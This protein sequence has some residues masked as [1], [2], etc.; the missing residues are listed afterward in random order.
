MKI[1]IT[2]L[3]WDEIIRDSDTEDL[4]YIRGKI[5]QRL[6]SRPKRTTIIRAVG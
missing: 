1:D 6:S 3:D 4:M 2:D 5:D